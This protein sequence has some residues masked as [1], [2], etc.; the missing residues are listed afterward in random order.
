MAVENEE[1]HNI[2]KKGIKGKKTK[3][4]IPPIDRLQ[5]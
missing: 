5:Y 1:I 2:I 4:N 3:M